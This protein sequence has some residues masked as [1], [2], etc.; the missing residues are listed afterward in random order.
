MSFFDDEN[1]MVVD[2]VIQEVS[3]QLFEDWNNANLDE[4]EIYADYRILELAGN[5]Y[6]NRRFNEFYD[7]KEGDEYYLDFVEEA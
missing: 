5:N 3:E 2:A 4:G 6:L 1:Q 7:L